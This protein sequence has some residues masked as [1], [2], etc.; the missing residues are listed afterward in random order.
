MIGRSKEQDVLILTKRQVSMIVA[1]ATL[2]LFISFLV[3]YFW[4]KGRAVEQFMQNVDNH[5]FADQA[6][7]ASLAP[8][9]PASEERGSHEQGVTGNQTRQ[10]QPESPQPST[11]ALY[12]APLVGFGSESYARQFVARLAA[13]GISAVEIKKRKSVTVKGKVTYWYQVVTQPSADQRQL[14][15]MIKKI[16]RFEKISQPRIV[17]LES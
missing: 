3:G 4:G 17:R 8:V 15:Q 7:S 9:P 11:R 6:Y 16:R 2:L 10:H 5:L 14:E 13:K 12:Y 1:A